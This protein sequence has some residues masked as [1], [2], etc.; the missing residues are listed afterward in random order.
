VVYVVYGEAARREA[1]LSIKGLRQWHDWPVSVIGD[2]VEGAERIEFS[3]ADE[4]GRWGKLNL[5]NL[6]PYDLTLY[7]DADT[8]P[9][10]DLSVGFD[11]LE[12]GWDMAITPSP[13][14]GDELLWHVSDEERAATLKELGNEPLALQA[15]VM[16]ISKNQGT[17]RLF[18]AWRNEWLRWRD[19][20]QAALLR[21]L[22]R[23]PVRVWLLG[24]PY[25]GGALVDHRFG[26][27]R[28]AN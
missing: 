16:Y 28:R 5:N 12:D 9:R 17:A 7:L 1:E 20:D 15:G 24:R 11:I 2:N 13:M 25:N 4:G 14:Q 26:M 21:A 23:V 3:R 18:S 19:Q 10:G 22:G 27:I 8:R 6:S